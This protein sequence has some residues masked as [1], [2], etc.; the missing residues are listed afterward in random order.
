MVLFGA[1][2]GIHLRPGTLVGIR[3]HFFFAAGDAKKKLRYRPVFALVD[4]SHLSGFRT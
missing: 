3:L 2:V 1:L 4:E